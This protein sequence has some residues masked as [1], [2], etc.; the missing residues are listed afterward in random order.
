MNN[1]IDRNFY[2]LVDELKVLSQSEIFNNIK[3]SF[4]GISEQTKLSLEDY[5][6]KFDYWGELNL[7]SKNYEQLIN[8]A[9]S[10]SEHLDDY[11]WLYQNLKDYRSKKLLFAIM[12]NWYRYDFITLSGSHEANYS[13]YFD[14]DL[15]GRLSNEVF[16]DLGAYIGDT[17]L[18]FIRI[19]GRNSYNKIYG[20][21]ITESTFKKLTNN[22]SIYDNII[23]KN[24]A[25]LD[26]D[27]VVYVSENESDCSANKT[28]EKGDNS[29]NSV[30]LDKDI[31]DKITILKMDIEGGEQRALIG[32]KNHI[33]ND[34]P[35]LLLSVYHNN[36][37]IWKIPRMID[38]MCPGYDFYLRSHGG[39][40]YPTEI[41]F[42][43]I[44][45]GKNTE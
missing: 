28:G 25:V 27:G 3:K 22:L 6:S 11:V 10:F 17:I 15:L 35:K 34:H 23:L 37:D 9:K 8:K 44:Y 30:T 42:I 40:I 26:N 2:S 32:C 5:F 12:N 31:T 38:E 24:N 29:V 4:D 33:V 36:E 14:L 1:I 16:V 21:E 41:T 19:Y 18:D 45:N 7:D 20:Y 43:A 13:H 39:S